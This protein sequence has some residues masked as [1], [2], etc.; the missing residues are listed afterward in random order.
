MCKIDKNGPIVRMGPS[1]T[2]PNPAGKPASKRPLVRYSSSID[3]KQRQVVAITK[4]TQKI[5]S[6]QLNTIRQSF[7]DRFGD[8]AADQAFRYIDQ[9]I[10]DEKTIR[11]KH[12][13]NAQVYA[14]EFVSPGIKLTRSQ[15]RAQTEFASAEKGM[16][17]A[18]TELKAAKNELKQRQSDMDM[19]GAPGTITPGLTQPLA[20]ART[21]LSRAESALGKARTRL[22]NAKESLESANKSLD[23]HQKALEKPLTGDEVQIE[24]SRQ[25]AERLLETAGELVEEART[26]L[27]AARR[28]QADKQ[29]DYDEYAQPGSYSPGLR[30]SL[31]KAQR[32]LEDA[33]TQLTDAQSA[34]AM[35]QKRVENLDDQL[36]AIRGGPELRRTQALLDHVGDDDRFNEV[37]D[38]M[39]PGKAAGGALGKAESVINKGIFQKIVEKITSLTIPFL[40]VGLSFRSAIKAEDRERR[41]ENASKTMDDRPFAK[42]LATSLSRDG[43]M[44][45]WKFGMKGTLNMVGT[46]AALH[47]ASAFGAVTQPLAGAVT[48]S[49][50]QHTGSH[51]LSM[52]VNKGVQKGVKKLVTTGMSRLGDEV[53]RASSNPNGPPVRS[54]MDKSVLV[55]GSAL[56]VI[57]VKPFKNRDT[58]RILPLSDPKVAQALLVY[59][60]PKAD[61]EMLAD[62]AKSEQE[63][64][65]LN[66]R[67]EMFGADDGLDLKPGGGTAED[68]SVIQELDMS[69]PSDTV[70]D[71]NSLKLLYL[72]M[73]WNG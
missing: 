16:A 7:R 56:P 50:T 19:Y 23:F 62:P 48:Q 4:G 66:L 37:L 24:K 21:R 43:E 73:G 35:A 63:E 53:V 28:N 61:T 64:R 58:E 3:G 45:K 41:L 2:N 33:K 54:R 60:G 72:G 30:E 1:L 46:G 49:V 47:G 52:G 5:S 38:R 65:R 11:G 10:G 39:A 12:V 18:E 22:S 15:Q 32:R 40:K 6:A 36:L 26:E 17:S 68:K 55:S 9:R 70:A 42:A 59:L 8:M 20:A 14:M 29:R 69:K 13:F 67:R 44:Q 71:T 27:Q 34:H 31:E 51:L 25:R 57:P